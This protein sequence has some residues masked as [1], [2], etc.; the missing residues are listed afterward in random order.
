MN[1]SLPELEKAFENIQQP[2]LL[3]IEY[4]LYYDQYGTPVSMSSHNHPDGNYVVVTKEQYDRPNYTSLK[5]VNGQIKIIDP[6]MAG[7][8][9]VEKSTT[10]FRVAKNHAGILADDTYT[11]IEYYDYRNR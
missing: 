6:A 11:E 2:S 9:G 1:Q 7:I 5:V 8:L 4:R 3:A 10:G